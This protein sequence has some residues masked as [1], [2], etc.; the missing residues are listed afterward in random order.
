MAVLRGDQPGTHPEG[1]GR[2][3]TLQGTD[4]TPATQQDISPFLPKT[5]SNRSASP[6]PRPVPQIKPMYLPHLSRFTAHVCREMM[7]P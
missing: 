6:A 4:Q 3:P 2:A 5:K 1:T 7:R